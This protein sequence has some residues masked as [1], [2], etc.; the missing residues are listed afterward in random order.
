MDK[1]YYE[2]KRRMES[3]GTNINND[4]GFNDS[5]LVIIGVFG[6][7]FLFTLL[8]IVIVGLFFYVTG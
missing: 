8:A 3:K 4:N 2:N 7:T 1:R 5:E 6:G